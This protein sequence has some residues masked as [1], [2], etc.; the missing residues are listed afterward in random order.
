MKNKVSELLLT[1]KPLKSRSRLTCGGFQVAKL[2]VRR[3]T[4][5]ILRENLS[6]VNC[7]KQDEIFLLKKMLIWKMIMLFLKTDTDMIYLGNID[8]FFCLQIL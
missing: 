6:F 1:L 2:N 7:M 5:F 8:K 3:S 4:K